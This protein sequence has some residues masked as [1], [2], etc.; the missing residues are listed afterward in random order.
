MRPDDRIRRDAI[1]RRT[2]RHI[3]TADDVYV[4]PDDL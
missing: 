2:N 4:L 1:E 3:K